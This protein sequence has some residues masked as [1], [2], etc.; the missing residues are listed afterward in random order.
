LADRLSETFQK[1]TFAQQKHNVMFNQVV[2][3]G[4][5][6]FLV[7]IA[8]LAGFIAALSYVDYKRVKKEQEDN[9]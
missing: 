6:S 8:V 9:H 7:I 5:N 1:A 3:S 4:A 2:G